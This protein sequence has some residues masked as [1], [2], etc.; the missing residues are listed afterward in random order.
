VNLYILVLIT[1][2]FES[3]SSGCIRAFLNIFE[4]IMIPG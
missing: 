1:K 3:V 4:A 2:S